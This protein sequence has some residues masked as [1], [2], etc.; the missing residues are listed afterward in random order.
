M[1]ARST[2]TAG[3]SRRA[4]VRAIVAELRA[5]GG[6]HSPGTKWESAMIVRDLGD[7]LAGR[8]PDRPRRPARP[9][10]R[11]HGTAAAAAVAR[12]SLRSVTT[13]AGRYGEQCPAGRRRRQARSTSS[14]STSARTSPSTAPASR[15]ITEQDLRRRACSSRCTA[16]ASTGSGYGLDPGLGLAPRRGGRRT[17]SRRS[18]PSR[19]REFGG[20]PRRARQAG[21]R[22]APALRPA[23]ALLLPAAISRAARTA[24]TT[25]LHGSS[26]S[27]PWRRPA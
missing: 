8:P 17:R 10:S 19:R 23:L 13:T 15:A 20:W 7:A 18:S 9:R 25:G 16:P 21:L 22:A 12:G 24:G 4:P 2:S 5:A 3:P 6:L 11:G 14:R 26:R 27:A 1:Q